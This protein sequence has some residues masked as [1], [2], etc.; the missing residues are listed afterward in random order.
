MVSVLYL[1]LCYRD[2]MAGHVRMWLRLAADAIFLQF[3]AG[4]PVSGLVAATG[5]F[6]TSPWL[7]LKGI[8]A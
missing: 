5:I 3:E 7:R 2:C 4:T 8:Y 1:L 6:T